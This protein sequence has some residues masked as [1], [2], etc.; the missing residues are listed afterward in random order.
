MEQARDMRFFAFGSPALYL[1]GSILKTLI[2][3]LV[4]EI[5]AVKVAIFGLK[6]EKFD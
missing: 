4:F 6:S 5:L 2:R 1:D 3:C